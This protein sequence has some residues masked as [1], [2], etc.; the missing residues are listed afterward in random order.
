MTTISSIFSKS[1]IAI[2]ILSLS[3]SS[4]AQGKKRGGGKR[5]GKILKQLDLTS[6]QKDQF[7]KFRQENKTNR[8]AKREQIKSLR[9]EMKKSFQSDASESSLRTLHA[10]LK[11]LRSQMADS[12]FNKMLKIRSV[13]TPEQRTKFYQLRA[14]K[15][16]RR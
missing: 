14:E 12:R 11:G 9:A 2:C 4:F 3:T 7:K 15:K 1:L 10:K 16:Q 13:L 5:K 6:E 8:K